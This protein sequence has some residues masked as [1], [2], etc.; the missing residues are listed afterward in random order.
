MAGRCSLRHFVQSA[1]STAMLRLCP[2]TR[3]Q[4]QNAN[5]A[6]PVLL[7]I[8]RAHCE[9]REIRAIERIIRFAAHNAHIAFVERQRDR[10]RQ[11][12]LCR[13]YESVKRLAQW[14][15]PQAEINKLRIFEADVLL[16]VEQIA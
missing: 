3:G 7:I 14:C 8:A 15:E 10:A 13:L 6:F 11:I 9:R 12:L 4:S 2:A 5:E 16:E 1:S